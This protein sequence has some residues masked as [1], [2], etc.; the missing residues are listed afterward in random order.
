[1]Q[2]IT[3]NVYGILTKFGYL[4]QYVI[5]ND[6]T[7]TIVDML[8]GKSD[9][10]NL[11]RELSRQGWS[12]DNVQHMLITHAHPDHIGGLQE[13][14]T[15]SNATTYAHRIDAQIIRGETDRAFANPD[16]LGWFNRLIFRQISQSGSPDPARVDVNLGDGDQLDQILEGLQV[17]HLPGH[18][19]GQIGFYIPQQKLL[20]GGDVMMRY[21]GSL[22]MPIRAVSPDWTAVKQS[23][24]RVTELDV[25]ILCFGHGKPLFNVN[26]VIQRYADQL[27]D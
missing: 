4:N 14:Q 2:K 12:L 24:R 27:S 22:R 6:D 1:M 8:L 10:D 11:E 15:R 5:V 23:I 13:F 19:H 25:E 16:E 21:F 7:L 17:I 26:P 3:D 20:I 18:S 9:V